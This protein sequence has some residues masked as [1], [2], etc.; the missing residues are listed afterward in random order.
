MNIRNEVIPNKFR[1][2]LVFLVDMGTTED[3]NTALRFFGNLSLI[4]FYNGC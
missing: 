3:G 1:L 4:K 2:E